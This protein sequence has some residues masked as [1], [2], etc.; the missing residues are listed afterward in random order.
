MQPSAKVSQKKARPSLPAL[1]ITLAITQ[2]PA[3]GTTNAFKTS[4]IIKLCGVASGLHNA[5]GVAL[6]KLKQ[7]AKAAE[8]GIANA[9]KLLVAAVRSGSKAEALVFAAGAV[10]AR[11]CT[12]DALN[13][14][15]RGLP[16]ALAATVST[17]TQAGQITGL[18]ELLQKVT[19]NEA[20][21]KC[22]SDS[23]G[24]VNTK[25]KELVDL[26]CP[27]TIIKAL[28]EGEALTG[29][30]I[31]PTGF[32]RFGQGQ[33][34]LLVNDDTNCVFL[35]SGTGGG[36]ELWKTGD[37]HQILSG[38]L[39]IEGAAATGAKAE[40]EQADKLGNNFKATGDADTAAKAIFDEVG[41]LV[42]IPSP[43]CEAD[44]G[45][46]L[47][48]V[49][50]AAKLQPL[51]AKALIAGGNAT[52]ATA[53]DEATK[54]INK[55]AK[56]ETDQ[57]AELNKLLK[58][59]H[60]NKLNGEKTETV[61]VDKLTSPTELAEALLFS[62]YDLKTKEQKKMICGPPASE[63]KT[64]ADQIQTKECSDKKGTACTGECELDGEICKPKKKLDGVDGKTVATN[65][66]GSNS[67]VINKAPLW[68][69]VLLF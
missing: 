21:R 32:K 3:D 31:T 25:A 68:L 61:T 46:Q 60:A 13:K 62:V 66:T 24:V 52:A 6:H 49:L 51:V 50:E 28:A 26:G 34:S 12:E 63:P 41:K 67:F 2:S 55:V 53:N 19:A 16:A 42:D 14:L 56:K 9:N 17:A 65:N 47:L 22:I 37:R 43:E 69:A 64:K 40:I 33:T 57:H 8:A 48:G 20:N 7:N 27:P 59:I 15:A 45:A 23:S 44:E 39:T 54:L 18:V 5:A 1:I 10:N 4:E 11:H 35:K 30:D 29:T 36:T 58:H 38:L